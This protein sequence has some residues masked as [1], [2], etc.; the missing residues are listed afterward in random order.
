MSDNLRTL[1]SASTDYASLANVACALLPTP[2]ATDGTK[3]VLKT[4]AGSSGDLMLPS[5]VHLL[6][7]PSVADGLGGHLSPQRR[8]LQRAAPPRRG[9]V[10]AEAGSSRRLARRTTRTVRQRLR[11]R[12]PATTTGSSTAGRTGGNTHPPSPRRTRHRTHRTPAHEPG[13]KGQPAT[14]TRVRRMARPMLPLSTSPT[15]HWTDPQRTTQSTQQRRRPARC[16]AAL[17]TFLW[18]AYGIEVAA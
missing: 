2:R 17:R 15:R 11:R 9:E 1:P 18:D 5:A 8:S 10:P 12:G 4:S 3:W 13:P 14:L 6:P 16:A 7:T